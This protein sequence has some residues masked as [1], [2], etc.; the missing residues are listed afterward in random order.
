L[1]NVGAAV[2]A[3]LMIRRLDARQ[4][5]RHKRLRTIFASHP[6]AHLGPQEP[7]PSVNEVPTDARDDAMNEHLRRKRR[8]T[9]R[10]R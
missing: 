4:T 2:A 6:L 5:E 9:R 8:R 7:D 1:I 3:M 10:R